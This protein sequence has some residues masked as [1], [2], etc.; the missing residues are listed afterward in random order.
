MQRDASYD[1]ISRCCT[2]YEC[3]TTIKQEDAKGRF[4]EE[5]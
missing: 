1:D 3:G 4:F 5:F 2:K